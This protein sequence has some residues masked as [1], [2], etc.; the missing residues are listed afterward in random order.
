MV[1]KIYLRGGLSVGAF[2]RIYGGSKSNGGASPHFCESS[3][4]LVYL[5]VEWKMEM[6]E[7]EFYLMG[8]VGGKGKKK[9]VFALGLVA[10]T[11]RA[12]IKKKRE[13]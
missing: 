8:G 1:R 3:G 7:Y 10:R 5:I 6:N 2:Q 12:A 9:E 11:S 4:A 13:K